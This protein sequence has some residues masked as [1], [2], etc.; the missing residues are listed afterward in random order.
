MTHRLRRF[1]IASVGL[2]LLC[3]TIGSVYQS[4]GA[5]QDLAVNPAPGELADIG[6]YRLHLYCMGEGGPTVVLLHGLG[7]NVYHWA[8]I[9]PEIAA[10]TR[11]CAYDRAGYGWSDPGPRPRSPLQNARELHA[12]LQR[13]G[14]APPFVLVGHSWGSNGAQVFA[15]EYPEDVQGLV[16]IDGGIAAEVTD[17]CP[18]LHCM[19][20]VAQTGADIFLN[21]QP[22]LFRVGVMRLFGFPQPFGDNLMYLTP[23]QRNALIAGYG[24]TRSA[25]ANLAEWRD[26]D[27]Q[28]G[29]V[30]Q[31]GSLG[32]LPVRVLMADEEYPDW[33]YGRDPDRGRGYEAALLSELARLSSDSQVTVIPGA[34]HASMLF[35][36]DQW[37]YVVEATLDVV[38][39]A[40]TR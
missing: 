25:D 33:F 27:N 24:Q 17:L 1:A 29:N 32:D 9:Q 14:I 19:P 23:S 15:E 11:V 10:A 5:R 26:W 6:G 18:T 13:A 20:R 38:E 28:V 3:A 2:V 37:Q 22:L 34:D 40:G 30:G 39:I 21:L 7:G 36:R 12:L 35:R 8:L 31:P 16:L 4:M